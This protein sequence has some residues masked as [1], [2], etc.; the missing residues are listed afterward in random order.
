M[1]L[2]AGLA[3]HLGKLFGLL[4]RRGPD[5]HWLAALFAIIDQRQD[6]PVLFRR[7]AIDLVV[8]VEANERH[9]GR[10]L[11][12][13]E[14]VNIH[15]LFGFRESRAGHAGKF[16]IHAEI[17][18]ESDRGERLVLGLDRLMFFCLQRLMQTFR[19]APARHHAAGELVNDHDLAIAHDVIFVALKQLV[20]SERLIDVMH[21]GN[22]FHVVE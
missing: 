4:D 11:E 17:V 18:L 14:A 19:V 15:K 2:P 10:H 9:V 8:V 6:R 20:C 22:V 3:Q 1:L 12:H 13:F 5:Q 21:D 16:F 7:S